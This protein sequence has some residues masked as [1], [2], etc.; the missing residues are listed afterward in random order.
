LRKGDGQS[1]GF[2]IAL[3]TVLMV[4]VIVAVLFGKLGKDVDKFTADSKECNNQARQSGAIMGECVKYAETCSNDEQ[5]NRA[6]V[7]NSA[8]WE[9]YNNPGACDQESD[10]TYCCVKVEV[11]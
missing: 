6:R 4:L 9:L 1:I 3:F 10:F 8:K 11:V 5:E 2:L 7:V